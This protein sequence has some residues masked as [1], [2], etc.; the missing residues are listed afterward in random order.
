MHLHPATTAVSRYFEFFAIREYAGASVQ[1]YLLVELA[2][3]AIIDRKM[4]G[5]IFYFYCAGVFYFGGEANRANTH[6]KR[7]GGKYQ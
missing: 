2:N 4:R 7:G 1:V 5:I 3:M 6:Y